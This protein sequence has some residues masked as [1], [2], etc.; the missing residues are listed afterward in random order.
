[1]GRRGPNPTPT[2]ALRLAGSPEAD[3]REGE[4]MPPQ[5]I[6]NP[7][8]WL[9]NDAR[10]YWGVIIDHLAQTEGL[11]TMVDATVLGAMC[12]HFAEWLDLHRKVQDEG[13]VVEGSTG[14]PVQNPTVRVRDQAWDRFI[15]AAKEFGLTPSS[16]ANLGVARHEGAKDALES[17]LAKQG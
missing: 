12:E 13:V 4:P 16:R 6:P 15:R 2:A 10:D 14:S 3:R 1:M 5:G 7:P 8:E 9:T 11:L 17:F